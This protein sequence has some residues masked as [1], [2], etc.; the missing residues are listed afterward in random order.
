[1][2]ATE[3]L[4]VRHGQSTWNASGRWQG[5]ADPPLSELGA[6]Q[7]AQ[8]GARLR[9]GLG[10]DRAPVDAVWASDLARARDTAGIIGAAL[11]LHARVD[12]RLRERHAG[13]WQGMTRAQIEEQW[14]GH[15]ATGR[16]P[17]GY[18]PD[19]E[20]LA[21]ALAALGEIAIA[22]AAEHVVVVTHGGIVRTIERHLGGGDE[23]LIPNLSG[24]RLRLGGGWE[25]GE[26]VLLLDGDTVTVPGQL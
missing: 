12:E 10:A 26:Q 8:A 23:G 13:P 17:E 1:V 25:L 14:P 7:A 11:G 15:L 22:H 21:R 9:L 20:V 5:Q 19:D 6:R 24:R 3:V 4:V 18:E 2:S 16:R